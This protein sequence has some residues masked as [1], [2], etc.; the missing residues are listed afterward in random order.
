MELQKPK[1]KV[2]M[3]RDFP[4]TMGF[5]GL[6]LCFS[7]VRLL[8]YSLNGTSIMESIVLRSGALLQ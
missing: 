1:S 2:N 3:F 6:G 8:F 7:F 5:D 4:G